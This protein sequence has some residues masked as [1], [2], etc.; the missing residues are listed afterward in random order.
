MSKEAVSKE[1]EGG[2]TN[3]LEDLEYDAVEFVYDELGYTWTKAKQRVKD[4]TDSVTDKRT[5]K[6]VRSR[7]KLRKKIRKETAFT[8]YLL[9]YL[10][11]YK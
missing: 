6:E 1:D 8:A 11:P 5:R 10:L 9:A 7:Q 4:I 2:L 3:F